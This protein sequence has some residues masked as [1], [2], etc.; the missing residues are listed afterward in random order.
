MLTGGHDCPGRNAVIRAVVRRAHHAAVEVS[1]V[2]NGW[3][4]LIDG[5]VELLD[6]ESVTGLLPNGGTLLAG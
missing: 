1:G 2:R 6:S 5:D 3:Q 4:G